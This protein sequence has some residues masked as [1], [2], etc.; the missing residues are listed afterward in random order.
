MDFPPEVGGI[1]TL[2]HRLCQS[3]RRV[4]PVVLAPRAEGDAAFDRAQVFPVLRIGG[5]PPRTRM[6]RGLV[7]LRMLLSALAI[8]RR[9]QPVAVLCMQSLVAPIAQ[10]CRRLL[11][12]PYLVYAHGMELL[13]GRGG[14]ALRRAGRVI[15]VSRYTRGLVASR[16]VSPKRIVVIGHGVNGTWS[17]EAP[18][19]PTVQYPALRG[20]RIILT[21]SRL[22]E[23]YKGHDVVLRSLPLVATRVPDAAYVVVGDGPLRPYYE[24]LAASLGLGDRVLFAGQADEDTVEGW[25]R[26]C[27]LL[28]MVSRDRAVDGGGEGFGLVYLEANRFAKPVVAGNAGGAPDAVVDGET[29]VLVDPE[30]E[31]AVA[32]ALCSLLTDRELSRRLGEQGRERVLSERTWDRVASEVERVVFDLCRGSAA[33]NIEYRISNDE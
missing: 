1:Q 24:G 27:D 23:L 33:A 12:R 18:T 32:D 16:D 28:V 20:K 17:S 8:A 11:G 19:D 9:E 14:G 29:G 7:L 10:V 13:S 4:S 26:A 22:S 31:I 25:Y 30:N 3:F 6:D 2:T 21:V 15:A 5:R